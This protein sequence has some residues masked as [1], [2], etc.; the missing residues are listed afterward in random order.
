MN[1]NG[2]LKPTGSAYT[3]KKDLRRVREQ[4]NISKYERLQENNRINLNNYDDYTSNVDMERGSMFNMNS[5]GGNR[6][7]IGGGGSSSSSSRFRDR[8]TSHN[9][10][11]DDAS[12]D[13]FDR[14]LHMMYPKVGSTLGELTGEQ[15]ILDD[16]PNGMPMRSFTNVAKEQ[17]IN[18]EQQQQLNQDNRYLRD[19]GRSSLYNPQ[20]DFDLYDSKPQLNVSYYDPNSNWGQNSIGASLHTLDKINKE[21]KAG[22]NKDHTTVSSVVI[23]MNSWNMY[24]DIVNSA[25]RSGVLIISPFS[26]FL[27][28][29]IL[30]RGSGGNTEDEFKSKLFTLSKKDVFNNLVDITD[31]LNRSR[32]VL[33]SNFILV[34]T[35]TNIDRRFANHTSKLGQIIPLDLNS[36]QEE[37]NKINKLVSH[38]THN[39]INHII[40]P[41]MINRNTSLML[42]S[43]IYFYSK[44]K[45]PFDKSLTKMARFNS[46]V[47]NRQVAMMHLQDVKVLCAEDAFHHT[48]ELEYQDKE[49]VMGIILSKNSNIK[50]NQMHMP[51][52]RCEYY[53][54]LVRPVKLNNLKLPKFTGVSNLKLDKY[55]K[56]LGLK[57]MFSNGSYP[58]MFGRSNTDVYVSDIIHQ[59]VITVNEDGAEAS[60]ATSVVAAFN[61]VSDRH[62]DKNFI[63]DHPFTFYIRHTPSNTILFV[64]CYV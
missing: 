23:S 33:I 26:V 54:S 19:I 41:N 51:Y 45:V 57:D 9:S 46:A 38:A 28:L 56:K 50:P 31:R 30:Y 32:S 44:W 6:D 15:F 60:A 25:D 12:E 34:P 42:V 5:A 52:E 8:F 29:T 49:F 58:D 64:G 11:D 2:L 7:G 37:S 1:Y 16:V 4:K 63:A 55:F 62:Q 22:S 47:G 53:A 21:D 48:V 20:L 10:Y 17:H 43:T 40:N 59:A 3:N 61:S 13:S 14:S 36:P 24:N 27:P 39:V 35:N 18:V